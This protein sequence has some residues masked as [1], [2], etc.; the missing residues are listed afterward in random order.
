VGAASP[1]QEARSFRDQQ[2]QYPRVR[3]A[4]NEKDA[5]LRKMFAEKNV[6]YPPKAI[7]LRAFKQEAQLELWAAENVSLEYKLVHTYAI[8]ATSGVLGPKRRFGD[9]Q[10]PEGF[11]ELDWLNAQSNFY[12]SLHISYP[13]S[14]D[15]ILGSHSNPGGDI[16]LHGNC[17]TIGCI[18]IRDD[19][20]KEVYWLAVLAHDEGQRRI[21]IEIFPARLTA[22]ALDAL[23]KSHPNQPDLIAFWNNLREGYDL[24]EKSHRALAVSVARDGKY[25]FREE[26]RAAALGPPTPIA[27]LDAR[28]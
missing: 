19:G 27:P 18:P 9:E 12:L 3:V 17:V 5:A 11:Y 14:A 21:P 10:V 26:T 15:R 13:N 7:L 1:A 2:W 4:A 24:F 8:C 6:A 25:K 22:S 28:N 20:I 16:F 23:A